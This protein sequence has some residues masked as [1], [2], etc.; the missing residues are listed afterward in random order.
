M[1]RQQYD[2]YLA[3]LNARD[4]DGIFDFYIEQPTIAFL[5]LDCVRARY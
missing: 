5:V 1:N 4:Y 2:D 3:K